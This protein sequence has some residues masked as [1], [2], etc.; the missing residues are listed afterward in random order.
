MGAAHSCTRRLKIGCYLV[1][2]LQIHLQHLIKIPCLPYFPGMYLFMVTPT[3]ASAAL[4]ASPVLG[5]AVPDARW[6]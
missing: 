6:A 1:P 3:S 4:R 2:P 5:L